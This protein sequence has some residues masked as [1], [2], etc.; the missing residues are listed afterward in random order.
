MKFQIPLG[1]GAV[2]QFLLRVVVCL[3]LL[4]V[5]TQMTVYFLPDYIGRDFFA[6]KFSLDHEGNIPTFYSF[7]G[8]LFSSVLLGAIAHVK[9]L[10]SDRYK[11][12]WKILS[13]IFL[14][15]S[16]DE[17]G[18]LHENLIYPMQ[19]LLNPTAFLSFTWIV[20]FSFL[21]AI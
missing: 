21:V 15:L 9:N 5:L 6:D 13:F 16:L 19:K 7:L 17:I 8:L 12:H 20:P 4:F 10:D 2:T 18:Q 14:Y 11:N 3:V 1:P